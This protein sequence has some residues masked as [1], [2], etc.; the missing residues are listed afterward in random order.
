MVKN[1]SVP[2]VRK[3]FGAE[4]ESV[5]IY[6]VGA[7]GES[8]NNYLVPG[9]RYLKNNSAVKGLINAKV[10]LNALLMMMMMMIIMDYL[11]SA[12]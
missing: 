5:N 12:V 7:E 10:N 2:G 8:V 1:N 9:E 6:L 11:Y 4:G 3:L